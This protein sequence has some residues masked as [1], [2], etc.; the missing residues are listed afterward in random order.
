V[1]APG[2]EAAFLAAHSP[3]PYKITMVSS[4][5]GAQ[6]WQSGLSD[7]AYPTPADLVTDLVRLQTEEIT[8]LVDQGVTWPQLDSLGYLMVVDDHYR[9]SRAWGMCR[10]LPSWSQRSPATRR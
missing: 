2:V 10:R 8:D 5:M 3:G 4:S 1:A 7:A 6:L 9:A